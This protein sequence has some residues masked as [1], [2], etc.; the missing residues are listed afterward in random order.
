M[1]VRYI[2]SEIK[3]HAFPKIFCKMKNRELPFKAV[4]IY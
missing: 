3:R 1:S 2:R 4:L